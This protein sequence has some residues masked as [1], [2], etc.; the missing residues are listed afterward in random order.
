[1]DVIQVELAEP[2]VASIVHQPI[3]VIPRMQRTP[4]VSFE[5][6]KNTQS[7]AGK[8]KKPLTNGSAKQKKPQTMPATRPP[9]VPDDVRS[10][11]QEMIVAPITNVQL[12]PLPEELV[13]VK[14]KST[15]LSGTPTEFS[16]QIKKCILLEKLTTSYCQQESNFI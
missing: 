1:M 9:V 3:E 6:Q 7:N 2:V 13:I 4:P 5:L 16:C 8:R 14:I 15:D 11:H 12:E 10:K